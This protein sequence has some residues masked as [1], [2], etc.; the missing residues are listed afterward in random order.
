L[1]KFS[2]KL[3][4]FDVDGVLVDVHGSF[5]QSILD[6]VHHFTGERVARADIQ[7]WKS[8]TGYN[9]DWR[10]STDWIASLGTTVPYEKVKRQ[11]MKFYWDAPGRRGNVWR[12]KWLVP[13]RTLK[14]WA[15]RAELTLF[16]GRTRKELKHTLDHFGVRDLFSRVVAM[17]DVERLKPDPEGIH[18]LLGKADPSTAIYLGDMLDDALAAQSAGVTFL[19][20]LPHGSEAHR[21][22]AK[23][24]RSHGAR[25]ILHHAKDLERYWK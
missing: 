1:V 24:L 25:V 22:R 13:P 21:V 11:F 16:T 3:L 6:T 15:T 14:R 17:E 20:V 18:F 9:D 4:I 5:H 8:K 23:Q 10:L 7:K 12:E 19:G 2:P